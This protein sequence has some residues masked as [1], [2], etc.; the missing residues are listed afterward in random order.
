MIHAVAF[1]AFSWVA[2][3]WEDELEAVRNGSFA[4]AVPDTYDDT[5]R[6]GYEA[7]IENILGLLEKNDVAAYELMSTSYGQLTI[8]VMQP[9]S[10]GNITATSSSVW[11]TPKIDPRYCSHDFDCDMVKIGVRFNERLIET[12]SM[13]ELMPV[14]QQ[15]FGPDVSDVDLDKAIRAAVHSD[16]HPSCT[17]AMLSRDLGGVVDTDLRVYGTSGLRVVDA[18]VFPT[19]PG[20]HLQAAVYAVAEKVCHPSLLVQ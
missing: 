6:A 8:S 7:Q 19:I 20:A 12:D 9:L 18:S 5:L 1:P 16:Y 2:D 4:S 10:R 17:A 11:D 13:A 15:G 3:N 14:P